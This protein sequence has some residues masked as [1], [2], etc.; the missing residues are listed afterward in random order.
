MCLASDIK[1]FSRGLKWEYKINKYTTKLKNSLSED[2]AKYYQKKLQQYH[3]IN[4]F[5]GII[6]TENISPPFNTLDDDAIILESITNNLDDIF[7]K[8]KSN[9]EL[10]IKMSEI[11]QS[12]NDEIKKI[13]SISNTEIENA[14]KG[15]ME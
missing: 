9:P 10:F 14:V 1:Q 12:Y 6:D 7:S 4:Q 11:V 13:T 5:G 15:K 3:Q 2:K 8:S